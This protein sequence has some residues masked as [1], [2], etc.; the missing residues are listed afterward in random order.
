MLGSTFVGEVNPFP[1]IEVDRFGERE[2][3]I[4]GGTHSWEMRMEKGHTPCPP[5]RLDRLPGM[6]ERTSTG[7][8]IGAGVDLYER[9]PSRLYPV[10]PD[11]EPSPC[12]PAQHRI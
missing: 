7:E 12:D 4:K 10:A 2:K 1:L 3:I 8:G 11:L 5:D 9:G 6:H